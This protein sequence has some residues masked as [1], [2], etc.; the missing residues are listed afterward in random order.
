MGQTPSSQRSL[1]YST[2][3]WQNHQATNTVSCS[4]QSFRNW[5]MRFSAVKNWRDE[6]TFASH[7][8]PSPRRE[9]GLG[10]GL[11]MRF[12]PSWPTE[13]QSG[14]RDGPPIPSPGLSPSLLPSFYQILREQSVCSSL[15]ELT[16]PARK[17]VSDYPS[18]WTWRL[19]W[20]EGLALH[21]PRFDSWVCD[22]DSRQVESRKGVHTYS[23]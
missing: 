22:L 1:G 17:V 4:L 20:M 11:A 15:K 16:P 14:E 18:S 5:L 21:L 2:G 3:R 8:H 9:K 7:L 10:L 23:Y 19:P 6:W 12:A 13:L